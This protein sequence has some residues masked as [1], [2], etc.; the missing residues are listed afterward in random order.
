MFSFCYFSVLVHLG[1]VDM[2]S[3]QED[4]SEELAEQIWSR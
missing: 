2:L 1:L 4:E 3:N